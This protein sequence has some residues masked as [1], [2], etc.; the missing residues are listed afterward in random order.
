MQKAK[1]VLLCVCAAVL[2]GVMHDQITARLCIE[3]FTI[4]HPPLFKTDSPTLLGF[5]WGTAATSGIGILF[6]IL[7]AEVSQSPE[8]PPLP[9]PLVAKQVLILLLTTAA[10]AV[11][12][13]LIGFE[14]SRHSVINLDRAWNDILT[15]AQQDRFVAVWFA[16]GASY[17]VGLLGAMFVVARM[18]NQRQRPRLFSVFPRSRAEF[19][20]AGIIVLLAVFIFWLRWK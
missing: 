1:V 14:L 2:Y 7:L 9:I 11:V 3:Y 5:L 8:I 15:L 13:G 4:A 17:V 12:A 18:W 16:H 19:V 6:G 20:R 10:A